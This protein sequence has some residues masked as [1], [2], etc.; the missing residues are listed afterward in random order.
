MERSD[1]QII[2]EYLNGDTKAFASLVG[3]YLKPVNNFVNRMIGDADESEDVTQDIFLKVWKKIKK[4]RTGSNFKIWIFAIA[5]NATIDHLRKKKHIIFSDFEHEDRNL[6][7]D[8]I[9]DPAPLQDKVFAQMQDKEALEK[10]LALLV[11]VYREVVLLRYR[12]DLTFAEIGKITGKP[13]HTVKSQHRRGLEKLRK[14][15]EDLPHGL[16]FAPKR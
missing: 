11:P 2:V 4:Y 9:A 1:E 10:A 16:D 13:L 5:R 12:E 7:T 6:L 14:Y 15:F 3:R 8:N